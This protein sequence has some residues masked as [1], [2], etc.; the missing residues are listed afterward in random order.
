[1]YKRQ[2][3]M[4]TTVS[5]AFDF[6]DFEPGNRNELKQIYPQHKGLIELLTREN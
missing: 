6:E 4:G 2:A 1:V 3:L 5:P